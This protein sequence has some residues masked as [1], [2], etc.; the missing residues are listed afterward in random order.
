MIR[1]LE[2]LER[3]SLTKLRYEGLQEFQARKLVA[4]SLQEQHW[5]S[6]VE[7]MPASLIGWLARWMKRKSQENK[8]PNT[9]QR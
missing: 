4:T 8:S 7:K 6:H 2:Q 3:R 1:I 5:N 9:R